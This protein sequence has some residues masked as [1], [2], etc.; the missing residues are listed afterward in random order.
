MTTT[1]STEAFHKPE[2]VK[3]RWTHRKII[4][5]FMQGHGES[6]T[7]R[8]IS[9]R[10]RLNYPQVHKRTAELVDDGLLVICGS[11]LE[12]K[13]QCSIYRFCNEPQLFPVKRLTFKQW[14]TLNYPD[15]YYKW[16][17]LNKHE[18]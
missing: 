3:I 10:V 15:I 18:L 5:H 14:V 13:N 11:K 7:N 4:S 12:G 9:A 2:N 8:E 1:A 6:L 16:Q 17:V